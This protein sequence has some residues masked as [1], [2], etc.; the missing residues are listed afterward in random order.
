[1]TVAV[2]DDWRPRLSP[3]L[4]LRH[5]KARETDVLLMPERV[6]VL[7]GQASTVLE[8]C[9]G[10]RTVPDIV[11]VLAARFPGAPVGDD[12][13]VFLERTRKEGWTR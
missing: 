11:A 1:M 8:L 7:H 9:D 3:G 6:V 4:V 12:V 10:T 13:G 2:A 5:D